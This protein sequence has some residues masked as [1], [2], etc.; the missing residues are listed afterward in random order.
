MPID[1]AEYAFRGSCC[2]YTIRTP[3]EKIY[4]SKRLTADTITL[5]LRQP[6]TAIR[7]T[8]RSLPARQDIQSAISLTE[9]RPIVGFSNRWLRGNAT[10]QIGKIQA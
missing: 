7:K 8:T 5:R 1:R 4:A 9:M 2:A 6:S 10:E 3:R